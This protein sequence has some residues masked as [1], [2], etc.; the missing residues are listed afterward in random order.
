MRQ[1]HISECDVYLYI[2]LRPWY[3]W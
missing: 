3:C 1:N 2:K